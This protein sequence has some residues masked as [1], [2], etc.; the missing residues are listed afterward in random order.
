[1]SPSLERATQTFPLLPFLLIFSWRQPDGDQSIV[2]RVCHVSGV[3][4]R[5]DVEAGTTVAVVGEFR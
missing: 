5:G 3:Q 1:V 4:G 2:R